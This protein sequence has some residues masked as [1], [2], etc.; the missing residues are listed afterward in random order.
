MMTHHSKRHPYYQQ[1]DHDRDD[2]TPGWLRVRHLVLRSPDRNCCFTELIRL[3]LLFR[4]YCKGHA[5]FMKTWANASRRP[6]LGRVIESVPLR[7][8]RNGFFQIHSRRF[9]FRAA[10]AAL[11]LLVDDVGPGSTDDETLCRQRG[12]GSDLTVI[13]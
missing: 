11:G 7:F 12:I 4:R 3:I 1:E 2:Y 5:A 6:G 9:G 10:G 13:G 8:L